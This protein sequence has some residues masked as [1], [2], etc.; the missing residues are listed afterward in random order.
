VPYD[1]GV[2][3]VR[4]AAAHRAAM[5]LTT[6]Y[7]PMDGAA[8]DQIDWN[9]EFSR[10][11]RGFPIYAALRELGRGGVADL[12]D[13]TCRHAQ[14]LVAGIGALSGADVVATSS[15]NQGLVRF[16]SPASGANQADHDKRTDQ[17]IAAIDASG[18]AFFGGVTF[19]GRRCM[20]IS[21]CNWRTTDA[22]VARTIAA[23]AAVLQG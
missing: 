17:V 12:V 5:T 13:R 10:R 18:E 2:A 20:R 21:V 3:I 16:L 1:S 23:V 7:L 11:A 19:R 22:D 8:R 9:P 15:L 6:S 4:D 14:A